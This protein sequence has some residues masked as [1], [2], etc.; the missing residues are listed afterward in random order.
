MTYEIM[1]LVE[2]TCTSETLLTLCRN[3]KYLG[4]TPWIIMVLHT[5]GQQ[6]NLH[7][8]IHCCIS[9]GGLKE[10]GQFIESCHKGFLL[11]EGAVG[12]MFRGKFMAKLKSYYEN[13]Q[14]SL[15]GKCAH[16]RNHYNWKE[17]ADSLYEKKWLPFI[18]E[19]LNSNGNPFSI[20][21]AMLTAQQ[22]VTVGLLM[23]PKT[24]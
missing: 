24:L 9:C 7:P 21:H 13:N 20:L 16:L 17:F 4:A 5:W 11:P 19:T 3:K 8:H 23:L 22:S 2:L 15:H 6:L 18:K 10:S 12:K 1:L 14:L